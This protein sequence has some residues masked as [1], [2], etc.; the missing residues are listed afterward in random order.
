M[1]VLIR[2][3]NTSNIN[4]VAES[5]AHRSVLRKRPRSGLMNVARL[6]KAGFV[7]TFDLRREATFESSLRDEGD[8]SPGTPAFKRRA[9]LK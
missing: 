6:F 5:R 4:F 9:K 2:L 7:L 8:T 3:V 1:N